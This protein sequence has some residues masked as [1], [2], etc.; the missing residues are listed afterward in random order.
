MARDRAVGGLGG[1][2]GDHHLVRDL[3]LSLAFCALRRGAAKTP[4]ATQVV[5]ELAPERP[6]RLDKER[7]IDRLVGDLHPWIITVGAAKPG[8]DL[9]RRPVAAKLLADHARRR[10][11]AASFEGFGRRARRHAAASAERAR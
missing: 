6:A 5:T 10:A 4:A 7:E 1:A 8:G 9:L 11:F 3:T 2:L